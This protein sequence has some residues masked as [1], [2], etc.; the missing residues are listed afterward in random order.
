MAGIYRAYYELVHIDKSYLG[1]VS[2]FLIQDGIE[3]LKDEFIE[4]LSHVGLYDQEM[5]YKVAFDK[6]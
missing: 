1:K 2:V 6:I 5:L 3:K 4:Q